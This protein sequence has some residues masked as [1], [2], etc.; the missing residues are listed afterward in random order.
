[1]ANPWEDASFNEQ[2][3]PDV[4][5]ARLALRWSLDRIRGLQDET[6]HLR[7]SMQDKSSQIAFLDNQIKNKAAELDRLIRSHQEETQSRRDSIE[8]QF[9]SRLERLGLR[10][11]EL[12]DRTA[13][14]EQ[15]YRTREDEMMAQFQKK[16]EELRSK[17]ATVETELWQARQENLFKQ[18]EIEK[19]YRS[20]L[21][22]EKRRIEESFSNF[23]VSL[24]KD[25]KARVEELERREKTI[26]EE[27]KKQ[28]AMLKWAKASWQNDAEAR[29]RELKNK[30]LALE[31]QRMEKENEIQ[32]L[33]LAA[34]S[35]E[36]RIEEFPE[37]LKKRDADIDRY[38]GALESLEGVVK[39]LENEK[40]G[41]RKEFSAREE[42]LQAQIAQAKARSSE[43][44]SQIPPKL[45]IAV[46]HEK[47][48]YRE[49]LDAE[50]R[51]YQEDLQYRIDEI[52]HLETA[53]KTLDGMVKSLEAE[54]KILSEKNEQLRVQRESKAEESVLRE[55][56]LESEYAVR[57]KVELER[58]NKRMQ[59]E[60]QAKETEYKESLK[61][62]ADEISNLKGVIESLEAGKLNLQDDVAQARKTADE[63][64]KKHEEE[65]TLALERDRLVYERRFA[66]E[67]E[68]NRALNDRLKE[69]ISKLGEAEIEFTNRLNQ[70]LAQERQRWQN[71]FDKQS[72]SFY[73]MVKQKDA[74]LAGLKAQ[75]ETFEEEKR[76]VIDEERLRG[77][78]QLEDAACAAAE[79][80]KRRAET[81]NSLKKELAELESGKHLLLSRYAS[82]QAQQ[83]KAF[84]EEL[85]SKDAEIARLKAL[86]DNLAAENEQNMQ[87]SMRG[88]TSEKEELEREITGLAEKYA[89]AE[90]SFQE[91][92]QTALKEEA[93]R[94]SRLL[95]DKNRRIKEFEE[96]RESEGQ[97]YSRDIEDAKQSAREVSAKAE[98]LRR[99]GEDKNLK[100]AALQA[101]VEGLEKKSIEDRTMFKQEIKAREDDFA[102][103]QAQTQELRMELSNAQEEKNRL[104]IEIKALND[105][106]RAVIEIQKQMSAA[107]DKLI[108]KLKE[109]LS[110]EGKTS[111][112]QKKNKK[113]TGTDLGG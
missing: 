19:T 20:A 46:E 41:L 40:Q 28:E 47:N 86:G 15:S 9:K 105:E 73:S 91:R 49:Q 82:Q 113:E 109:K 71:D 97:S 32:A 51:R 13:Q 100:L 85:R 93:E 52:K 79:E 88:F 64:R 4:E 67:A 35:L 96:Q 84:A 23:K 104:L 59:E 70:A 90:S 103:M 11:K 94:F 101:C 106:K 54:R 26:N 75:S 43:I 37:A 1:M 57:L 5:T 17:W 29:E 99:T 8:Q 63:L 60:S 89:R 24:E 74:E 87:L 110:S 69:K 39:S 95:E 55:K 72:H 112:E 111:G 45:K 27:M 80:L 2:T 65:L 44:E 50:V 12:E 7:Q 22:D 25:Y 14:L 21:E 10:E 108:K 78:Q 81:V 53:M 33:K 62:K 3:I 34:G 66:E 61:Y 48:R 18:Q 38:R 56:Q 6:V 31:K 58:N 30:E 16:S 102:E 107:S 92:L 98:E 83:E 77:R 76:R 42:E 68:K 36:R